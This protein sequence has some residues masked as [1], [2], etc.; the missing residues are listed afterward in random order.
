MSK[1]SLLACGADRYN[2]EKNI[3]RDLNHKVIVLLSNLSN[4]ASC[5]IFQNILAESKQIKPSAK[6]YIEII[7]QENREYTPE[8]KR[9]LLDA[10]K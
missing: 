4:R 8:Q 9:I 1:Y 5:L 7:K 3:S 6:V 2:Y 10:V